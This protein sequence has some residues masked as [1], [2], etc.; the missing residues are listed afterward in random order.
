MPVLLRAIGEKGCIADGKL[1]SE[2][3]SRYIF[4]EKTV[5]D[6]KPAADIVFLVD[7]SGSMAAEHAWLANVSIALDT[8]LVANGIGVDLPNQFGLIG[9]AKVTLACAMLCVVVWLSFTSMPCLHDFTKLN[10][11]AHTYF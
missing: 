6:A 2:D 4:S 10:G 5:R 1:M 11:C 7:E 3:D 9:F 8:S